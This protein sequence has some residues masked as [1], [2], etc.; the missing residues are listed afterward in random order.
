MMFLLILMTLVI[1]ILMGYIIWLN[2]N[3]KHIN[4]TLAF[5]HEE[6]SMRELTLGTNNK[7]L[8][9]LIN[10]CNELVQDKKTLMM[11]LNTNEISLQKSISNIIHDTRTPLAIA[12]GYIQVVEGETDNLEHQHLLQNAH[13]KIN[14][15]SRRLEMLYAISYNAEKPLSNRERKDISNLL[16]QNILHYYDAFEAKQIKVELDIHPK[17]ETEVDVNEF[18][19]LTNNIIEN[20]LKY[21]NH[22]ASITAREYDDEIILTFENMM[23]HE[24]LD[25]YRIFDR[26]QT[27]DH[28]GTGLGLYLVQQIAKRHGWNV[29]VRAERGVFT[30]NLLIKKLPK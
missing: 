10:H 23:N 9:A 26:F 22:K 7:Q 13:F 25:T 2:V 8:T 6:E 12:S 17:L 11:Q 14:D 5:I 30:L 15:V 21:G 20:M 4:D 27:F 16:K 1:I 3:I 19:N 18:N 29:D 24:K 28:E